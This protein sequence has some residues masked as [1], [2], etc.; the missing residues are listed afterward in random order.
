MDH[1][2]DRRSATVKMRGG[3]S[4]PPSRLTCRCRLTVNETQRMGRLQ[5]LRSWVANKRGDEG[6][7]GWMS[8]TGNIDAFCPALSMLLIRST[9]CMYGFEIDSICNAD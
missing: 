3:S 9:R 4:L 1:A 8:G 2:L 7:R 5:C 6:G